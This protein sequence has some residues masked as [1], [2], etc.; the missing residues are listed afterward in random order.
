MNT[1]TRTQKIITEEFVHCA[2]NYDSLEVVLTRGKGVW[3]WDVEGRQYID[4]TSAYCAVSHGHCH[5]KIV[6]ALNEQ[7]QRLSLTSR[8]FHSD[9]LAPFL[10]KLCKMCDL[11]MALVMNTGTEA[12]ETAIKAARLWGYQVKGIPENQAQ[13]I[14]AENN[15]HGRTITIIGFSSEPHYKAGFGPFTPGFVEVNFGECEAIEQAI[16]PNTCALLIEPIQGEAGVYVPSHGYLKACVELA[17]KHNILC[18][19]DEVQS[20]LGRTGKLFAHQH[21]SI[22]P[23]LMV[24][25]KALGGGIL[26]IS[27]VVGKREVMELF[28]PGMHGSTFGGNPLAC[29]VGLKALEVLESE[30]LVQNSAKL[31]AYLL[32]QLK[33]MHSPYVKKIRG[34]GLWVA[35]EVHSDK[36]SARTLCERLLS[37]GVLVK[38]IHQSMIRLSPPLIISREELD[39]ALDKIKKVLCSPA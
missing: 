22:K 10:D 2:H 21:E 15:F 5:P 36:I 33:A 20:G 26:P 27:A 24:V 11:D 30:N 23:D 37:E 35:I 4:M 1:K 39:W 6:H 13:I 9:Q 31:G 38:D 3:L 29:H 12:V 16:T 25:G 34:K 32:D 7:A 28:T 19:F 14:V 17:K 18:I 8:V